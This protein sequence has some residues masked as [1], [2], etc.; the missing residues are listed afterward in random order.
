M[1]VSPL[2]TWSFRTHRERGICRQ[3]T[4]NCVQS[5]LRQVLRNSTLSAQGVHFANRSCAEYAAVP[6]T[7]SCPCAV[8]ALRNPM[9]DLGL[10]PSCDSPENRVRTVPCPFPAAHKKRSSFFVSSARAVIGD[11]A[12][13]TILLCWRLRH[14]EVGIGHTGAAWGLLIRARLHCRPQGLGVCLWMQCPREPRRRRFRRTECVRRGVCGGLVIGA[15]L[16][17]SGTNAVVATAQ[18]R[19]LTWADTKRNRVPQ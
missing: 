17:A 13:C 19:S 1:Y 12:L 14:I 11:W 10:R 16:C 2:L 7:S 5:A 8:H 6:V 15:R 4:L 3:G 18:G 9:L